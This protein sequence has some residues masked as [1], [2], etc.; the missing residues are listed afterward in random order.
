[1]IG[2]RV[3]KLKQCINI[4]CELMSRLCVCDKAG[5]ELEAPF[6]CSSWLPIGG[7]HDSY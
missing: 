1:M 2:H 5:G 3:C 6:S 4:H 7:D